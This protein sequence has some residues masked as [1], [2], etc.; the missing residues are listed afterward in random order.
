MITLCPH[1]YPSFI[2]V[3]G[4]STL[5]GSSRRQH[6]TWHGTHAR[7]KILEMNDFLVKLK[8]KKKKKV[9]PPPCLFS[10]QRNVVR[11]F[12]KNLQLNCLFM[13]A[14]MDLWVLT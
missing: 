7:V 11:I 1:V 12:L 13:D 6:H 14:L 9:L 2:T 5:A 10:H 4:V 3:R 8:K